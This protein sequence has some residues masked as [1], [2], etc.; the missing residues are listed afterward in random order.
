MANLEDVK[1]RVRQILDDA[2]GTRFNDSMLEN[3]VRQAL[4]RLD[5]ALPV[6]RIVDITRTDSGR[7]QV[8]TGLESPLYLI[9]VIKKPD[10][11]ESREPE[12]RFA[13]G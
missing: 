5:V 6:M 10:L 13:P 9:K 12:I 2:E 8:L 4:A 7:E 1:T 11:A 3:A